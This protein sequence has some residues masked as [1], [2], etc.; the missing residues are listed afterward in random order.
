MVA[1]AWALPYVP[2]NNM[3]CVDYWKMKQ[4]TSQIRVRCI[5]IV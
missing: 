1:V 2:G 5:A 4:Y 3:F